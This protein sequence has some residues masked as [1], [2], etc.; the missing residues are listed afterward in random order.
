MKTI[1][2]NIIIFF[3][4]IVYISCEEINESPAEVN[5]NLTL[6]GEVD[7]SLQFS[8]LNLSLDEIKIKAEQE[9]GEKFT[10]TETLN[11]ENLIL[12]DGVSENLFQFNLPPAIYTD[13][14]IQ[15]SFK[16]NQD[17]NSLIFNGVLKNNESMRNENIPIIFEQQGR[18][19]IE[20]NIKSSSRN[21][22]EII[23]Q[24]GQKLEA[25][26]LIDVSNI[27]KTINPGLLMAAEKSTVKGV[28]TVLIN[29]GNNPDIYNSISS[30]VKQSFTASF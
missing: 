8:N 12:S 9:N 10:F 15:I 4:L 27:F 19:F 18:E 23:I 28:S 20:L 26:I 24:R 2:T 7:N 25:N 5:M 1:L 6:N 13:I 14:S 17:D 29:R 3:S 30:K 16:E 22:S 11:E 21:N